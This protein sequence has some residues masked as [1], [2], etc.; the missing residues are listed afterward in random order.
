MVPSFD[1]GY[2]FVR[3]IDAGKGPWICVGFVEEAVDGIFEFPM[4]LTSIPTPLTSDRSPRRQSDD[5]LPRPA[6][7]LDV[8]FHSIVPLQ[9][10]NAS[11]ALQKRHR[12]VE[13][14]GQMP[15]PISGSKPQQSRPSQQALVRRTRANSVRK[16]PSLCSD[17]DRRDAVSNDRNKTS[18]PRICYFNNCEPH[19]R[20]R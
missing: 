7:R 8:D 10:Q 13:G 17:I 2:H 5:P 18:P 14:Q 12:R 15:L 20:I 1:G 4:P 11:A 9:R 3:I 16:L 6:P 19:G